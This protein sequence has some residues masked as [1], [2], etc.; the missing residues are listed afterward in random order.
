MAD[1]N[2]EQLRILEDLIEGF[3]RLNTRA[4]NVS[5][6]IEQQI[7][8][9]F[10]KKMQA[11]ADAAAD[12]AKAEAAAA[13]SSVKNMKKRDRE[14]AIE[15]AGK[16]A[17]ARVQRE[18]DENARMAS[19]TLEQMSQA[20]AKL[21]RSIYTGEAGMKKYAET[22]DSVVT[23]LGALLFLV[24][25]PL[26]KALTTAVMGLVKFGK[27]SAEMSD[28]LFKSYQEISRFGAATGDGIQGV[29][30]LMQGMRLSTEQLGQL[31]Q[32]ISENA[33][34]LALFKGSVFT[35]AK[36]MADMRKEA[37]K[38]GLEL[39]AF[40]LGMTPQELNETIAGFI[41]QQAQL[42]IMDVRNTEAA[43]KSLRAYIMETDAITK[44]TGA[45]RKQQ[46]DAMR[47]AQAIEQ[48]RLKIFQLEQEGTPEALAEAQRLKNTFLYIN[49]TAGPG[50]AKAFAQFTTGVIG[51]EGI[52]A[53][54]AGQNA[55][56]E[57]ANARGMDYAEGLEKLN[58]GIKAGLAPG[59]AVQSLA[60]VG[61]L[62]STLGVS[63]DEL[64][65]FGK[66]SDE[67]REK[68]ARAT[69]EQERQTILEEAATKNMVKTMQN[70]LNS[71]QAMQDF[72]KLGV[73]PA[74]AALAGLAN[75]VETI[76]RFLPKT[77]AQAA[78]GVAAGVGGAVAGAKAGAAVGSVAGPVGAA[79]V[80]TLGAVGGGLLGF[81]GGTAATRGMG[82]MVTGRAP[83][84]VLQF[85][86]ESGS[87]SAFDGLSDEMK[88]KIIA[89]GEQYMSMTGKKLQIN[90]AFRSREKQ[91]E[92]YAKYLAGQIRNPVAA[93]GT[94]SHER[95]HAVDIQNYTDPQAV[96]A[97]NQQGLYQTVTNDP[98]HFSGKSGYLTGGIAVGPRSGYQATLHGSEAVVPLPDGKTIPVAMPN[99][100]RNMEQQVSMMGAQLIA[101]EELVRYMRDNNTISSKILQA[102]NN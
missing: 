31:T 7:G 69:S 43:T 81:F 60:M 87:R 42:G 49:S 21:T 17:A 58:K 6:V 97:M 2:P 39:E 29:Y 54:V 86:G 4:R 14:A 48:F 50:L 90:S 70:D 91:E 74:T 47:S 72:V 71:M 83:D 82:S 55:V 11:A 63:I 96:L 100:D 44:L 22:V 80:G 32:L 9:T 37:Q 34:S 73:A 52:G 56:F 26:V 66:M 15:S 41:S 53:M 77:G 84:E 45:S 20:V 33:Q 18:Y 75:V 94:S 61:Q 3:E 13:L 8:K 76:T 24:G 95:G 98:M 25:N 93:P 5:D 30:G 62:G 35:G 10:S 65:R 89:A 36:S 92:L 88:K 78:G 28:S 79:V 64:I 85:T 102:A 59:G 1:L 12:L 51:P 101:L 16:R 57:V 40:G 99:L 67:V 19:G 68:L 27:A 38:T 46:E 23:A